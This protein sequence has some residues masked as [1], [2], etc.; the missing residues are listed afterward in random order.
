MKQ[1]AFVQKNEDKW[2]KIE[3]YNRGRTI[4]DADELARM[5]VDITDELAYAKTFYP[6]SNLVGYLNHLASQLH[7][8]IYQN[9]KEDRN[10][11]ITYWME[12]IPMA[13]SRHY[14][15]L[16]W[17]F[18]V[19]LTAVGIGLFSADQEIDFVRMILGDGYVNMTLENIKNGDP[20][21]VYKGDSQAGMFIG[22]GSNNIRV[23]FMAFVAGIF[24]SVFT[25]FILF[26]NGV[27][28]G[29]FIYF[30]ISEGL[31][32]LSFT[33]IMIHG[34]LELSA[35][36]IAGA[37]GMIIGNSW[38][39][40]GTYTR[41]QSLV[42]GARDGI[43]ILISLLPIFLVAAFLESFVTRHYLDLGMPGRIA[44]IILSAAY[45]FWYFYLLP[46]KLTYDSLK[47]KLPLLENVIINN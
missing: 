44:I 11:V 3:A 41:I 36:V 23:S 20:M 13:V 39:F 15:E 18:I 35:I 46:K 17:S 40:P 43:K 37:A 32:G 10:R 31:F 21:A 8:S 1:V 2:K 29:A 25:G 7:S 14:N 16:K 12:E 6:E 5:Y 19:F 9:K 34:T 26:S 30:F 42:T 47:R 22:I 28:V 38:M 45:L 33:A 4:Y 24:A 27:M